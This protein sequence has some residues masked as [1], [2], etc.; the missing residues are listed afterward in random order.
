MRKLLIVLCLLMA[1]QLASAQRFNK[2]F[3]ECK[4]AKGAMNL[5]LTKEMLQMTMALKKDNTSMDIIKKIDNLK[6]VVIPSPDSLFVDKV[7]QELE[8]LE[9][10]EGYTKTI[11]GADKEKG[12]SQMMLIK[13]EGE[14]TPNPLIR[15][16]VIEANVTERGQ[17][18]M[19]V[20]Q[21][22]GRFDVDDLEALVRIA[23]RR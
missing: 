21:V 13:A 23:S 11:V 3:A 20:V 1:G 14:D 18:V 16:F 15:E 7:K 17:E 9:E 8:A 6:M 19:L 10:D 22:L 12:R 2:I 5:N 4:E